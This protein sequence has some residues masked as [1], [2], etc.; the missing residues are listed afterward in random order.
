MILF[1]TFLYNTKIYLKCQ[2]TK[3][4]LRNKSKEATREYSQQRIELGLR[5]VKKES[6]IRE[7]VSSKKEK[8]QEKSSFKKGIVK[9]T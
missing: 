9:A 4:L 2:L 7:G 1:N 6:K 8:Y 3:A 5:R